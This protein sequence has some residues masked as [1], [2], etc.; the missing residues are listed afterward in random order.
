MR[1]DGRVDGN[2]MR[3]QQGIR[4]ANESTHEALGEADEA[5]SRAS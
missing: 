1:L 4:V 2:V 3:R 5:V